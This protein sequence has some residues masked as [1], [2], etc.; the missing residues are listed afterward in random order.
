M[1]PFLILPTICNAGSI[2]FVSDQS[3]AV[4]DTANTPLGTAQAV[5]LNATVPSSCPSGATQ[6]GYSFSGWGADLTPI[7][8]AQWIWAPGI[9]GNSSPSEL[10]AYTFSKEVVLDTKAQEATIFIAVDDFSSVSVN[11]SL[12]GAIGSTTDL[13]LATFAQNN[14]TSFDI[15][16]FL[17]VGNNLIAIIAQNGIGAFAGCSSCT[18]SQQPAGVV[19]GVSITPVPLPATMWLF[20]SGVIG[21]LSFVS[22]RKSNILRHP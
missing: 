14:L 7:P 22:R 9:T 19:F 12:V 6:Y 13:T 1:T 8:G 18:Y 20:G 21:L 2:D 17:N 15:A 3:W 11:G 16:P 5:C 4:R 10:D